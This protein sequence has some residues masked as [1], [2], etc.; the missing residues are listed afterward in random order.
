MAA[1]MGVHPQTARYRIA[2]LRELY[3]D[4]LETPTRGSSSSSRC[5]PGG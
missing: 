1:A 2:R 3:G 4:A 5:A